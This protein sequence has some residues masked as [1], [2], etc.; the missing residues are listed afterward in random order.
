MNIHTVNPLVDKRWN[1]LVARHPRASAFHRSGWLVALARTYGYTPFVLT[2][3][4]TGESPKRW[5][6]FLPCLE[7]DDG[8]SF[9]LIPLCRLHSAF[10][11]SPWHDYH[12]S[13]SHWRDVATNIAGVIPL[14]FCV[15]AY[16]SSK[17]AIKL[18]AAITI[19]LGF[20]TSLTIETL[21]AFLPTRSSGMTDIIT[22]TR[23]TAIGVMLYRWSFTQSLLTEAS[24]E[25]ELV[26]GNKPRV[27][28]DFLGFDSS[29]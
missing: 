24:Q 15:F 20:V 13:W 21:Q 25:G 18:A 17:P 10:L 12:A 7:L 6:R 27:W 23:G 2:S 8:H 19:I 3:A 29:L 22:N 26:Y 28:D 14:G 4:S 16:L 9:S 5:H 11:S 1:D